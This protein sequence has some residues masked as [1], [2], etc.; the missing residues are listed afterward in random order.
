MPVARN[1]DFYAS[2]GEMLKKVEQPA[3][4]RSLRPGRPVKSRMEKVPV[5][6]HLYRDQVRWLDLYADLL[7]GPNPE[8]PRL[9]RVEIVRAL[10]MA[11]AEYSYKHRP[12][13]KQEKVFHWE[14]DLQEA[15]VGALES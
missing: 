12:E 4:K 5:I 10:L 8:N 7:A 15:V 1:S 13:F 11:L 14:P 9:S 2:L 3:P 6:L